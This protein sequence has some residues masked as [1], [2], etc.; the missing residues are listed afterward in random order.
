MSQRKLFFSPCN[1]PPRVISSPQ[2]IPAYDARTARSGIV[3]DFWGIGK[4]EV[5][6]KL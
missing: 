1:T 6:S 4:E 5:D 2:L 3:A